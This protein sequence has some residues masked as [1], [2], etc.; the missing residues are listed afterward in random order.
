MGM[1]YQVRVR[2]I[3]HVWKADVKKKRTV[4][5]TAPTRVGL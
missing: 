2:N 5:I 1:K 4:K 3:C